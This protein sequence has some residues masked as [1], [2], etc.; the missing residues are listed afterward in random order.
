MTY[1]ELVQLYMERSSA[2]QWFWTIYVIVI[3]G[4]LAFSSLRQRKDFA[5]MVLLTVLYGCF[6]Y[7]NL[8]AIEDTTAERAAVLASLQAY[9]P[10]ATDASEVNRLRGSLEP[11][12]RPSTINEVRYFHIGC[13]LLTV[14]L[15]WTMEWRRQ[16]ADRQAT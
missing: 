8:G 6:A 2:L 13:D 7:K 15:L 1:M 14:A 5:T 11:T 12:L 9:V 3:G 16:K 10:A 4:L